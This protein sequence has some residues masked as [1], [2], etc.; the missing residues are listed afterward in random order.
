[1]TVSSSISPA[2]GAGPV[3]GA[4]APVRVL[5]TDDSVVVRKLVSQALSLDPGIE[6]VGTA[7]NGR[8]ALSK[9]RQ[10]DPDLVT[11]DIEMP[12]MDGLTAVRELRAAG[13]LRPIVMCSTLTDR[14]A[15]ATLD[16]LAAGASDYVT[17]P[18]NTGSIE[19]SLQVMTADLVPKVHALVP[20]RRAP[21]PTAATRAIPS[22]LRPLPERSGART[23]VELVVIGSSTGGPSALATMVEGL[24]GRPRVPMVV[25]Q[26]MPPV[27]T[28]QLAD[29]LDRIGPVDVVEA[30]HGDP[31]RPGTI[32]IAP[33]GRHLEV[34]AQSG[35][36]VVRLND[37]PPVNYCRPSVDVMFRSAAATYGA[38]LLG[39][40]LTGM[41]SD[42]AEGAG[43]IVSAGGT[44]LAQDQATSVVWGM[45]GAVAEA[46]YAHALLPLRDVAGAIEKGLEGRPA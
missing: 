45:P 32:Y 46:G 1:M 40:V 5:V 18:S 39:V 25:V 44:V 28:R 37:R 31:L 19:R 14:G 21:R 29:R 16:A 33:G 23:T 41:G 20:R 27:F 11:M 36:G 30:Q 34:S 7:A 35:L 26:H 6:V 13:Y 42:G 38:G 17:K 12:E 24:A 10:L 15:A 22:R 43:S 9:V 8:I 2:R 4:P 3:S